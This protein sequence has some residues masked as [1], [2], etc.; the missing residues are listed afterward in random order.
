[1]AVFLPEAPDTVPANEVQACPVPAEV[2][3]DDE[4][5]EKN[6]ETNDDDE[7]LTE[8]DVKQSIEVLV[9]A[10]SRQSEVQAEENEHGLIHDVLDLDEPIFPGLADQD[11]EK[12]GDALAHDELNLPD[13]DLWAEDEEHGIDEP[14]QQEPGRVDQRLLT[15]DR[16]PQAEPQCLLSVPIR[17]ELPLNAL[18]FEFILTSFIL[19]PDFESH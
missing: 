11:K 12:R 16:E 14:A 15:M 19:D 18:R 3:E 8:N 10:G 6:V 17:S 2:E 1:M 9:N 7:E 13:G 4:Q 5:V